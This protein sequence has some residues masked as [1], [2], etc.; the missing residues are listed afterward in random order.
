MN[1][2]CHDENTRQMY[3][4]PRCTRAHEVG[5]RSIFWSEAWIGYGLYYNKSAHENTEKI[6]LAVFLS[7]TTTKFRLMSLKSCGDVSKHISNIEPKIMI[8]LVVS[9][10]YPPTKGTP[11]DRA[12]I[13]PC[14]I[15]PNI[16]LIPPHH[17][18][19]EE[20]SHA[21]R[22]GLRAHP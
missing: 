8:T 17:L 13:I 6:S 4:C 12:Y 7:S 20:S 18:T 1:V 19:H 3:I 15:L 11:D 21:E 9:I 5:L 2:P 14:S 22:L 10:H 16:I